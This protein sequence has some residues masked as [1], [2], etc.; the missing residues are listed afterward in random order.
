MLSAYKGRICVVGNTEIL[1]KNTEKIKIRK[2]L[3]EEF[4]V[5]TD[6]ELFKLRKKII[7]ISS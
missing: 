7:I 5:I 2:H 4:Y 6:T 1:Y 3:R